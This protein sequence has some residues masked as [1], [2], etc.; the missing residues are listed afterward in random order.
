MKN[1]EPQGFWPTLRQHSEA[2]QVA[3][4]GVLQWGVSCAVVI[5]G[6]LE[7]VPVIVAVVFAAMGGSFIE[8]AV[9]L[10]NRRRWTDRIQHAQAAGGDGLR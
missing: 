7:R 4:A 10:V 3:M 8:T 6:P 9:D 1:K 2:K 5:S